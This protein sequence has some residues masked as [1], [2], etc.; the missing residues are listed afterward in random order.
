MK[1][2]C[3]GLVLR[4]VK[5]GEAD[6]ILSVLTPAQGI[7]SI[8]AKGSLRP[9]NKLFSACGLF[10]YSEWVLFE[11]KTMARADEATPI[12]VFFGL[13][14]SIEGVALA[15]YMAEMLQIL[16]PTGEEAENLLRLMLNSLHLLAESKASPAVVKAVFELRALAEA[17]FMPDVLGCAVCGRYEDG[18]FLFDAHSGGL[19]CGHCAAKQN[20]AT[21]I[22][23][24][25]LAALRH[26][27]LSESGKVFGFTLSAQSLLLLRQVAEQFVLFN[28]DYPPKS[29][30]F[31][32]T[33]L[34]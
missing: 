18:Q 5:V 1:F 15:T 24:A 7:I 2:K 25:A 26:I 14:E 4:A 34:E 6:Q 8:S 11:G 22:D 23:A 31:L 32:K 27:V 10:S 16:S 17:G 9:K 20:R 12:E 13:R 19:V 30:A 29:L 28:F 33:V 3:N 21:N